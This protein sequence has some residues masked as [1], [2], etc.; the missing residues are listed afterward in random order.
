MPLLTSAGSGIFSQDLNISRVNDL[1]DFDLQFF[2]RCSENFVFHI[3]PQEEI[4]L[5]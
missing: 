1:R 4:T 5:W 2:N 3:A